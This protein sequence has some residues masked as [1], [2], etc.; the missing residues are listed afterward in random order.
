M[1][2]GERHLKQRPAPLRSDLENSPWL[3][4]RNLFHKRNDLTANLNG[5]EWPAERK[6]KPILNVPC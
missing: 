2:G 1:R 5:N 3:A 6:L 4:G